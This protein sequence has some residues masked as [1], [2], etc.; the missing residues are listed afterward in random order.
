MKFLTEF[1]YR[2]LHGFPRFPGDST[3]LVFNVL[4]VDPFRRYSLSKS[5]LAS[6]IAAKRY[7]IQGWFVLIAYGN[8]PAPYPT[9]PSGCGWSCF[10]SDVRYVDPF[11]R[12]SRSK[13]KVVR[14]RAEIWTFLAL[15]NFRVRAFQ[16]LYAVPCIA[17]RRL[18]KFQED[19]P[20]S[21]E[22]I[23]VHTMNFKPNFKFSRL[24]FFFF[25]G[26]TPFPA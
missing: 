5:K 19:I 15:P 20:T 1:T 18:E 17:T 24:Q 8:L 21:P 14:N 10:F 25:G 2:N 9:V 22:V 13:L 11:W 23:R 26:G 4:N 3:A 6:Q 7:Q 16:K 12:Y